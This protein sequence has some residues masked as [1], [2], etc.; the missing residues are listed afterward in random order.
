[1]LGAIPGVF[2]SEEN[3]LRGSLS[4]IAEPTEILRMI[5]VTEATIEGNDFRVEAEP[6][7]SECK[8]GP[9]HK[10]D[11]KCGLEAQ[12]TWE[13]PITKQITDELYC[14][15]LNH[16]CCGGCSKCESHR[17]FCTDNGFNC[18]PDSALDERFPWNTGVLEL[19]PSPLDKQCLPFK[20]DCKKVVTPSTKPFVPPKTPM[21][22]DDLALVQ[23]EE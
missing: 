2:S 20:I 19:T 18:V 12:A 23:E 16:I 22:A 1:M 15:C 6:E 21:D 9:H 4:A 5:F 10:K 14:T 17:D 8:P 13:N 11:G 7:L 3:Q